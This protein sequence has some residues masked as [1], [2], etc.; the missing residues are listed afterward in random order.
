MAEIFLR[1][2]HGLCI[3]FFEGKGYSSEFAEHMQETIACLQETDTR[4]ILTRAED[5]ICQKCP[6]FLQQGCKSKEKVEHY[7]QR[8]LEL[9]DLPV[10]VP[11]RFAEIQQLVEDKIIEADKMKT[12]CLDCGWAG[13]CHSRNQK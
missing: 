3:H 7:D 11:L 9:I 4:V 6:N 13:L 1:P 5:E 12:V 8:V 10:G 2:H